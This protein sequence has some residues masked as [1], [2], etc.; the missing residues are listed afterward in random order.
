MHVCAHLGQGSPRY[1]R[2]KIVQAASAYCPH[3]MILGVA[4]ECRSE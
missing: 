2:P 4:W 1:L 3:V